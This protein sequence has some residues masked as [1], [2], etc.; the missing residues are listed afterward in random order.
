MR[1]VASRARTYTQ[2][3]KAIAPRQLER[4]GMELADIDYIR[5]QRT[6]MGALHRIVCG[7][8]F[9]GAERVAHQQNDASPLDLRELFG[10]STLLDEK[11]RGEMV[12]RRWCGVGGFVI[13]DQTAEGESLAIKTRFF[14]RLRTSVEKVTQFYVAKHG[15]AAAAATLPD[16]ARVRVAQLANATYA[17]DNASAATAGAAKLQE[18]VRADVREQHGAEAFD[19]LGEAEQQRLSKMWLFTCMRHLCNTFLDGGVASEK[20]WLEPLLAASIAAA[21]AVLRL[22]AD[23]NKLFHALAKGLG[24]GIGLY[25]RGEGTHFRSWLEKNAPRSLYLT[26]LRFDKGARMDGTTEAA[27]VVY[28]NRAVIMR[29]LQ[30]ALY[31]SSNLLRDN[32]WCTLACSEV[33]AT[34]RG[35][36]AM[37]D[38]VMCVLEGGGRW[39]EVTSSRNRT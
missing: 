34:L 25:G 10:A 35:R 3:V 17:T 9:A 15:A 39:G 36:A 23:I 1:R 26:L 8:A 4:D 19:A 18:L 24:E 28:F 14:D 6:V 12:R 38:K 27:F 30:T 5:K 16:A 22:S 7:L 20:A 37:H 2:V 11:V 32:L 21:P 31:A 33:I 13:H 29:Y